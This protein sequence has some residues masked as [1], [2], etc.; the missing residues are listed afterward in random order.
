MI[1]KPNF[2]MGAGLALAL[3]LIWT[4]VLHGQTA[5]SVQGAATWRAPSTA[6][7]RVS[8]P[9]RVSNDGTITNS[10][11]GEFE[12]TSVQELKAKPG[13]VFEMKVRI[14]TDLHTR[15]W[16]ELACYDAAG[17]EIA[18]GSSLATGSG[19]GAH[20]WMEY[21]RFFP[22]R[23]G[24]AGVRA[25]IRGSGRGVTEVADLVFRPAKVDSYQTGAL[26]WQPYPTRRR[27]V[28]LESNLGI[29]NPELV[30]EEDHDN[31][32]KWALIKVDLDKAAKLQMVAVVDSA[33]WTEYNPNLIYWS[34]GTVLKSDTVKDDRSPDPMRALHF[35]MKVHAGPYRATISDP[36]RA[37]AVSLD[38][39]SWKRYEGGREAELGVLPMKDG[40]IELWIDACYRD[41]VSVGPVYFDYVRLVPEDDPA[42]DERLFLA[43]QRKPPGT[44][45][46]SADE[47]RVSVTVRAP[48][49]AGGANWPV[50]CGIPIPQGELSS[51]DNATVLDA[52][53][54]AVATQNRVTAVWLDGSVKWL[55]LDF[56][57]DFSKSGEAHYAVAYGNNV[58]RRAP[59][60]QVK[61]NET[62]SGVEVD[63]GAIRFTVPR[64]RFGLIE[65]VRTADGQVVQAGPV[66]TEITELYSE[67]WP[68]PDAKLE[69]EQGGPLHA[70]IAAS[71]R[72]YR[73]RIHAYAGSPLVEIDYFIANMDNR[74][75]V[76]IKSIVLK[77]PAA[78]AGSG[79]QIAATADAK[80]PG[81]VSAGNIGVGVAAFREQYPK[82]LRWTPQ[83]LS[84]DLW[85][86]EGGTYDWYQGVGKTHHIDL[87]YAQAAGDGALLANGPVLAL[88]AP[89]WYTASGVF[90]PIETAAKSPLPAIEKS[91]ATHATRRILGEVGLGFENYGDHM[92]PA[93]VHGASMWIDNEYDIPAAAILDFVRTGDAEVLRV[94]LASAQ[95]YVDVDCIHFS[96]NPNLLGAPHSHSHDTWG[97]HTA[98][99]PNMSHAGFVEGLIW[100]SNFTGDPDGLEGAKGIADW[101]LRTD[102]PEL[103]IGGMERESGH[104]IM[105]LDDVYEA[106]WDDRYLRGSAK[107]V[108]WLMRWEYPVHSGFPA[109]IAE[110]PEYYSGSFYNNG[111]VSAAL[112]KFNSWAKQPEID[113]MLERFGRYIL[114]EA[115]TPEGIRGKG[116]TGRTPDPLCIQSHLRLMRAEYQRTGDPLFLAV[117]REMLVAALTGEDAWTFQWIA[118][119]KTGIHKDF[120]GGMRN[121][122]LVFKNVPWFLALLR[123]LGNPS[124]GGVEVRPVR[125]TVDIA[126]GGTAPVCFAV[127]NTS[128]AAVQ[129]LRIGFQPRLDFSVDRTPAALSTLAPGQSANVCY[130]VRA[131]EKINLTLELNGISYAHWSATFRSQ[132]QL[133][134]AHAWVRMALR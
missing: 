9:V 6:A 100:A 22:V 42:T 69:I 10:G 114:T 13:D 122:G 44:V 92:A 134:V 71:A 95:H 86:P 129:D 128:A 125:E 118:L 54:A 49:F 84:I 102:T 130:E 110:S 124:P 36:G 80:A 3:G 24:A 72:G 27:G 113:A 39:K 15:A 126:K 121:A 112:L 83:G 48:Q 98:D 127:K 123:E 101:L 99:P 79:V 37:V 73:A 104:P 16:P 32:G 19:T 132:G 82:A 4:A 47:R 108:D 65:N 91:L 62:G 43:A 106:T 90:G 74:E 20:V 116:T 8:A 93:Y 57:H 52:S 107:V 28:V 105:T 77:V 45:R 5:A 64:A 1:F 11:G 111:L 29:V 2:R 115:W 117:P 31:D 41:P 131:P 40:V 66:T 38:G 35:R 33:T 120:G 14:K 60:A 67:V 61:I 133:G 58:R 26:I 119:R 85:A 96:S 51:A 55:Y 46:G 81:W 103:N 63:T 88:A 7:V 94:G 18:A 53:G 12:L 25:R 76:Q 68:V 109:P 23:P 50:R 75:M 30:S 87:Y 70:V 89:E 34:D 97:H 59:A 21:E 78:G 17:H 56:Q